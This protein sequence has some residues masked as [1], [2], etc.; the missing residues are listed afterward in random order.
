VRGVAA[1]LLDLRRLGLRGPRGLV[2]LT[3]LFC[4]ENP[5]LTGE[6]RC[7]MAEGPC[8]SGALKLASFV[9]TS[10][11]AASKSFRVA[12][13]ASTWA[14]ARSARRRTAHGSAT[15]RHP[16]DDRLGA[17]VRLCYALSLR[18]GRME[19]L[20]TAASRLQPADTSWPTSR[21]CGRK[22]SGFSSPRRGR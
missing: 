16:V 9:S 15:R 6:W 2:S 1:A 8:P 11:S 22:A 18:R 3:I 14:G 4:M 12:V 20:R 10:S 13:S 19:S 5:Y 7:G 21:A 17:L